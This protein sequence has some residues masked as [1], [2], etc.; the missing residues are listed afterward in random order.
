[1]PAKIMDCSPWFLLN[2]LIESHKFNIFFKGIS[3]SLQLGI[4]NDQDYQIA[5]GGKRKG[6]C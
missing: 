6:V 2:V 1:M 3:Q 4:T 5:E